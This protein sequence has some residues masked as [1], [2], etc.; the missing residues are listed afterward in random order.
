MPGPGDAADDTDPRYLLANERTFL[1]WVRT[2]LALIAGGL[3]LAAFLPPFDVP[4]GGQLLGL[5]LTAFGGAIVVLAY[6]R[7]T[8]NDRALRAGQPLLHDL[9][10]AVLAAGVVLTALVMLALLVL[11]GRPS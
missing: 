5:P 3:A 8:H 7:W 11:G 10:P 9:L 2:S 1:A 6:R 4:G